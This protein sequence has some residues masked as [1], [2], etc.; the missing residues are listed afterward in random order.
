MRSKFDRSWKKI[1]G[2]ERDDERGGS[3]EKIHG[4]ISIGADR[5]LAYI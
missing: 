4:S 1:R 2:L 5:I 3:R